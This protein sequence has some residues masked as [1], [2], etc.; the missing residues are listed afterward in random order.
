MENVNY[1]SVLNEVI[2][3]VLSF[4]LPIFGVCLRCEVTLC[5]G[6][7][8]ILQIAHMKLITQYQ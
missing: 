3:S 6:T 5:L 2:F 1:N 7:Y 4:K 8:G